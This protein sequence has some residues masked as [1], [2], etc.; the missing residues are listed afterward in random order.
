[1]RR[2]ALL[3]AVGAALA[4]WVGAPAVHASTVWLCHPGKRPNPCT[5]SLDFT[6]V[7][8]DGSPKV[9]RVKPRQKQ[10]IDCFYVYP[11]VNTER[12]G[13]SDLKAGIEETDTAHL[14]ASWFSPVCRVFAPMYR[15]VTAFG[16]SDTA[17]HADRD[18]A[19][20]DVLAAWRDYLASENRG[21]GVVLIG[22]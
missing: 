20:A 15:Q 16:N 4:A 7:G 1:M 17:L 14:Q 12:T 2:L 13:N 22:H 3:L 9:Y 10:P 11:T 21:R 8:A 5:R 6:A 19:Y 18:L